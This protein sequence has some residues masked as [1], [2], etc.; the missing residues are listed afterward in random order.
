MWSTVGLWLLQLCGRKIVCYVALST[1]SY[2]RITQFPACPPFV[3]LRNEEKRFTN[4]L[5]SLVAWSSGR[6]IILSTNATTFSKWFVPLINGF[7][8]RCFLA[9]F[10]R[11]NRLTS[12]AVGFARNATHTSLFPRL[13]TTL[14]WYTTAAHHPA[15]IPGTSIQVVQNVKLWKRCVK[16]C[17]LI[18]LLVC[19]EQ[20]FKFVYLILS[21]SVEHKL[22]NT[23]KI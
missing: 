15:V 10:V 2:E 6:I 7:C 11:N 14:F 12:V 19:S 9:K 20:I 22:S 5:H 3:F 13:W 18:S 17:V 8:L 4:I 23:R 1:L 21:H 16:N